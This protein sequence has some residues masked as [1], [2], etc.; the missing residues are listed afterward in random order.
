MNIAYRGGFVNLA[1]DYICTKK[2]RPP[3]GEDGASH[4]DASIAVRGHVHV[5]IG[6]ILEVDEAVAVEIG[7]GRGFGRKLHK[8]QQIHV[9]GAD[10]AEGQLAVQIDVAGE[11]GRVGYRHVVDIDQQSAA[12]SVKILLGLGVDRPSLPKAEPVRAGQGHFS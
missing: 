3:E 9:K 12:G 6:D 7:V 2:P 10:I 11:A 4:I 1:R 5:E 8:A